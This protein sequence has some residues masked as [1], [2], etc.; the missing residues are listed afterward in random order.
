MQSNHKII[1]GIILAVVATLVWSGNFIVARGVASSIPPVS[2]NFYR[3]LCASII[4]TPLALPYLKAEWKT[5]K[6]S[7]QYLFWTALFGISIF[8]TLVYVAGHYTEA[9]NL[10]LIGTTTSPVISIILARFFLKETLTP[11]RL[12]GLLLC[13]SGIL[14]LLSKG[15]WYTLLHFDFTT[16]DW[17]ILSAAIAF[18]IYNIM[19][20]L[21][22]AAI[23]PVNLL[24]TTF[25]LGTILLAPFYV[26]EKQSS[27]P[28][29]WNLNKFLVILYL[30]TGASVTAF[31]CW[32]A[33][34]A[35]LGAGRTSL[36]GNLIPIFSAL[37][38]VFILNEKITMIHLLSGLL[39]IS[40]LVLANLA[41]PTKR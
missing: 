20:R 24:F 28:V 22:P 2:L 32:N 17:W 38:A 9:I 26:L 19:V 12:A 7:W 30:G 3:W 10:A 1:T 34:I 4:I 18:A 29:T 25:V 23:S 36:F 33:A 13:I 37:E 41:I 35:R 21:K 27:V 16:G 14:L 5:V 11:L 40:G 8:N 39:V 31:F 15:S 6:S